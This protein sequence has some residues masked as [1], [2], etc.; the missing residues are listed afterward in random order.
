MF[1][2]SD[3]LFEKDL[4]EKMLQQITVDDA[5]MCICNVDQYN[6]ETGE[7]IP[8]SQ[9][10]RISCIPEIIPFSRRE[11][12]KDILHF[13]SL[14][15]W[16]KMFRRGFIDEHQ[17]CFQDIQRAND[18]Y[19]SI[20]ALVLAERITVVNKILVHYRVKQKGNLTTEFSDTPLCSYEAMV[21]AKDALE[22]IGL[23]NEEDVRCS[24][25]NKALNIMIFSLNIQNTTN[26]YKT[27]YDTL[28]QGGFER[29]GLILRD[30]E[31][32]NDPLEY[33]NFKKILDMTYDEYLLAKNR[34][35]RETIARKNE[36]VKEK[37][38]QIRSLKK[39]E[40]EYEAV[41]KRKWYRAVNKVLPIYSAMIKP[42]KKTKPEG[43]TGQDED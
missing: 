35:Y 43:K 23:M 2:D 42:F 34:E 6:T 8:K 20:L 41:K 39:I 25:D 13:T 29:L 7:Y 5:D 18:Q 38:S 17:L 33:E 15:P 9:Y 36:L 14:V 10:L 4:I 19:F 30:K 24:F 27:L 26:G 1:L 22:D 11:I 40:R 21:K 32:Y 16:N 28:T 31:Y 3:D 37:N 12:G